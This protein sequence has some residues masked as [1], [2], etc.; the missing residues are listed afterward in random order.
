MFKL[1]ID[2]AGAGLTKIDLDTPV[3]AIVDLE[4]GSHIY[5]T[6]RNVTAI[7][8]VQPLKDIN[9]VMMDVNARKKKFLPD[10]RYY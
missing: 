3:S 8:A 1:V 2:F 7:E 4:L 5:I 10:P 6:L 9:T